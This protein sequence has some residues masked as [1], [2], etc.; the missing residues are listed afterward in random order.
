M[1]KEMD[2]KEKEFM[3]CKERN[4]L[5]EK[6][7]K[8]ALC[9][10]KWPI[11][12]ERYQ[13]LSLLGSGGFGEVYKCFDLETNQYVALKMIDLTEK[14][15]DSEE[16]RVLMVKLKNEY[17]I[18]QQ[19]KHGNIIKF[20]NLIESSDKIIFELEYCNGIELSVYLRKY[21]CLDEA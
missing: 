1:R 12:H 21:R 7:K 18:Q 2:F 20:H 4:T 16:R 14:V 3:S 5:A 6:E 17:A 13:S 8:S 9:Q 10:A 19:L 11:I 15:K